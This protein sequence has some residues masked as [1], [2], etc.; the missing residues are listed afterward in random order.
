MLK[1]W[2]DANPAERL[3]LAYDGSADPTGYGIR[4]VNAFGAYPFGPQREPIDAPGVLAISA[5]SLQGIRSLP[6][7]EPI[8]EEL[9]RSEPLAV[10]GGS[11]YLYRITPRG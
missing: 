2:Q 4:Y 1:A 6:E 9:R 3:Y 7:L 11:I 5:T 8:L 10:L